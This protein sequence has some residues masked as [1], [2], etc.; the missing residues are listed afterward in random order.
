MCRRGVLKTWSTVEG[1]DESV[2]GLLQ[3]LVGTLNS[4]A[5]QFEIVGTWV[6]LLFLGDLFLGPIRN[7]KASWGI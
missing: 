5:I 1:R 2:K 6:L 3:L 7:S 4:Y